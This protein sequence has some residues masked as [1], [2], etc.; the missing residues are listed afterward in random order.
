MRFTGG[1]FA[2]ACLLTCV[3]ACSGGATTAA[4]ATT[5]APPSS[6][7]ASKPKPTTAAPTP[8][9][10]A[11]VSPAKVTAACP[12]L[13]GSEVRA[14]T[15]RPGETGEGTEAASEAMN[16]GT[17]YHCQYGLNGELV[18]VA[19]PGAQSPSATI[20]RLDKECKEPAKPVPGAGEYATHCKF[21]DG[22]EMIAVGK[23]GHG[24]SRFA[25]FYTPSNRDDVYVSLAK[26]LGDRL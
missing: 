24:Q 8:T 26:L 20:G 15:G 4:P 18:V 25:Q 10:A 12:F 21:P 17:A 11:V 7:S 19:I 23:R 9:F 14:L 22:E 2:A 5:S 6:T 1:F 13:G 3:A 16:P